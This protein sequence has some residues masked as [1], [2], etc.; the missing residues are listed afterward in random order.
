MKFKEIIQLILDHHRRMVVFVGFFLVCTII[1]STFIASTYY[2]STARIYPVKDDMSFNRSLAEANPILRSFGGGFNS[3]YKKIDFY[4]PDLIKSDMIV[5][6]ILNHKFYI[7][8]SSQKTRLIN[9]WKMTEP[10]SDETFYKAKNKLSK[11]IDVKTEDISPKVTISIETEDPLLSAEIMYFVVNE[12]EK[13][14][15]N[16]KKQLYIDKGIVID[17]LKIDYKSTF[18]QKQKDLLRFIKENTTHLARKDAEKIEEMNNKKR[19]IGFDEQAY[20][21]LTTDYIQT[22]I[23]SKSKNAIHRLDVPKTRILDLDPI[24]K[25]YGTE[26]LNPEYRINYDK[27]SPK[28]LLNI[29]LAFITASFTFVYYLLLR[30][31]FA[32]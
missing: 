6:K 13:Y 5:E 23:E 1:Y 19:E 11:L 21:F 3:S 12:I 24:S 16:Q 10:E 9:F 25:T 17:S 8:G 15:V 31:K 22:D 7:S 30:R 26:I 32:E 20:S 28:I 4:I 2:E 29:M 27:S 14:I 18:D